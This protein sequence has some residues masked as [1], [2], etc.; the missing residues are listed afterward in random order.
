MVF[1]CGRERWSAIQSLTVSSISEV[2]DMEIE[3]E[4][5]PGH[6]VNWP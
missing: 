4:E 1:L 5:L 3:E 2:D 6:Q